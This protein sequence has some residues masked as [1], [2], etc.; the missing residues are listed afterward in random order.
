M[1][2]E[3]HARNLAFGPALAKTAGDENA[4]HRFEI[5]GEILVTL[6]HFGV[7][8]ADVD[9][10]PVRHAAVDERLVQRLIRVGQR[11]IF[12]DDADRDFAFGI[13]ITIDDIFPAREI[14]CRSLHREMMENLRVEPFGMVL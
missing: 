8:P 2:V 1:A 12:A 10:D 11:D 5:G 4:V 14:R 6:E 13:E 3:A 9:L 7:E